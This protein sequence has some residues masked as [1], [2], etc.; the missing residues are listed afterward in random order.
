M[1]TTATRPVGPRILFRVVG[2]VHNPV[3]G[4]SRRDELVLRIEYI[5]TNSRVAYGLSARRVLPY[6]EAIAQALR[7]QDTYWAD[8]PRDDNPGAVFQGPRMVCGR[9]LD[10]IK[11]RQIASSDE[12]PTP[13]AE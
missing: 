11:D 3:A 6:R 1:T 12:L 13:D 7:E 9:L 8:L 2:L 10:A 4:H 5:E